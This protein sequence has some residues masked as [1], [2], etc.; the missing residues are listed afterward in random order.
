MLCEETMYNCTRMYTKF[1][2]V[3]MWEINCNCTLAGLL[4]KNMTGDY[5][6]SLI[7]SLS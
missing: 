2:V 3:D 6:N 5:F 1:T 7:N 4:E